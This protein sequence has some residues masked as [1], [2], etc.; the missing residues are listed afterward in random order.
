MLICITERVYGAD[1]GVCVWICWRNW[2]CLK[3]TRASVNECVCVNGRE[4]AAL[5]LALSSW[6]L[7][8]CKRA[9]SNGAVDHQNAELNKHHP[10]HCNEAL[11]R[12]LYD[13]SDPLLESRDRSAPLIGVNVSVQN[14]SKQVFTSV[15]IL[16]RIQKASLAVLGLKLECVTKRK[17]AYSFK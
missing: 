8:K 10:R 14:A 5:S 15:H 3:H 7:W 16:N 12:I 4:R 9:F 1:G 11:P 13:L 2:L 17:P 6:S